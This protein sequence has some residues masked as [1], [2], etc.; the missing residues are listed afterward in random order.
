[1]Y[2]DSINNTTCICS[3]VSFT[4]AVTVCMT[5]ACNIT[6][7]L[8]FQRYGAENCG[9]ANDKTKLHEVL[10]IDYTVPFIT[11]LFVAGRAFARIRLDVGF[12]WDDWV[13]ISAYVSYIIAVGT[14]LGLVL[15]G[16]GEHKF[17]LSTTQVITGLKVSFLICF[18]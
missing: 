12:G 8:K 3:N 14:S 15:N 7:I 9:V 16:F 13:M 17:W 6:D 5:T 11:T 18:R 10:L 1:M 2:C 4:A